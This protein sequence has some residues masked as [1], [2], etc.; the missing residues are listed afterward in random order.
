MTR[1]PK[2]IEKPSAR[3]TSAVHA[4]AGTPS[5]GDPVVTPIV[6]SST[7]VTDVP[8][9][10]E[11]RYTRYANTPNQLVVAR[12]LAALEGAEDAVVVAS[13]MAATALALLAFLGAGDHVVAARSLYGGTALLLKRDL[14]RLGVETT[15][16]GGGERWA[17][18]LRA[19]T[20]AILVEVPSN[21][22]LR[23]T[24]LRG[25]ARLAGTRGLPLLVDATFATP[26]LMRPLEHG[27]DVVIHSATKYL[28]GHSDLMAGV[29]AG[30]E[31][32]IREVR[33]KL[34]SFGPV[35]DAHSAWLLE[36]G[37]KTLHVRVERQTATA[38]ELAAWLS[39][40]PAVGS[41]I[42]PGLPSHPDHVLARALMS[43]FGGMLSFTVR[44]GD[45]AALRVL[46]RLR[47]MRVAPS[48]GGVETLVS[49]PRH[50]SHASLTQK[51]RV[52]LGIG[53]GF[54]RVSVGLEDVADL[55]D[56]LGQALDPESA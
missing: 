14:S 54:V 4:G 31:A 3:S 21:P 49:M 35:L 6:P 24:D 28:G 1:D 32:V 41:T 12:K 45:A 26:I 17:R 23:L 43:G 33:E 52:D 40:H 19:N 42:Y 29:V 34:K 11:V 27:A 9:D 53:P 22:T 7:Y 38:G 30:S 10:G 55:R 50:T 8:P 16:V 51:E 20:R 15:F 5:P 18:A 47:L 56:D 25:L 46:E 13:G 39:A 37:L 44:G 36:R 48:L 2:A